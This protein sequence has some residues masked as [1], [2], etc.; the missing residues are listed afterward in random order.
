MRCA[1]LLAL[2]PLLGAAAR[3]SVVSPPASV[4][5]ISLT[6]R[7]SS[8]SSLTGFEANASEEVVKVFTELG[9]SVVRQKVQSG[10]ENLLARPPGAK[11]GGTPRILFN[12]HLDT[13]PPYINVTEDAANI[14]GRGTCDAKGR[15][16]CHTAK[17]TWSALTLVFPRRQNLLQVPSLPSSLL[18]TTWFVPRS[19]SPTILRELLPSITPTR[20]LG[21]GGHSS[22]FFRLS[23]R[24]FSILHCTSI[25]A[26][27]GEETDHAGAGISDQ[28][29]LEEVCKS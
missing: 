6:K 18:R 22:S 5:V 14:Y 8:V 19:P 13:V 7:I 20:D 4:D 3:F 12:G 29:C 9:W 10:R 28:V 11:A 26:V 27:V 17:P 15:R 2:V 1:A 16:H 21:M 25:L 23:L 24:Y